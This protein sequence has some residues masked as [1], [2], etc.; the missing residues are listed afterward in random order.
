MYVFGFGVLVGVTVER[1][2]WDEARTA[3]VRRYERLTAHRRAQLIEAERA[4]TPL[5][6]AA[7]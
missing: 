6:A 1:I 5:P 3:V 7:R 4:V 2:R